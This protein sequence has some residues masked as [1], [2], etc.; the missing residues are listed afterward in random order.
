MTH[1]DKNNVLV[2]GMD[3]YIIIIFF[4]TDVPIQSDS[5]EVTYKK[6][7]RET[8]GDGIFFPAA[9]RDRKLQSIRREAF[10]Q[11]GTLQSFYSWLF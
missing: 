10:I 9:W 4:N 5:F 1:T 11:G 8:N 6:R 3:P 7:E 2:L